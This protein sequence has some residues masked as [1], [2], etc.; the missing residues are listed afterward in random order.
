[1]ADVVEDIKAKL[2]IYTVISPHVQLK[3]TGANY[4]GCCPFHSEKTGSFIVSPQKQIFHCFG[5]NK[6]GD[7]FTFIQEFENVS[8]VEAIEILADKAGIKVKDFKK[9]QSKVSK[10][11][12]ADFFEA[13]NLAMEFYEKNLHETPAGKI[14]L[15]YLFN[16]GLKLE[17]IRE[18]HL[19]LA[20]DSYDDLYPYLIKKGVSKNTILT[21]GLAQKKELYNDQ[22]FD[23]FHSRIMFPIF[24]YIGKVCGFGG[25]ALKKDQMPKYLNSPDSPVYN[26]SKIL[27]G[28]NFAKQFVKEK[29][30]IVLVEGYFDVIMPYQ[31]G[32]KNIVASSG[33]ALTE[34]HVGII[35]RFTNN[36]VTCFDTDSA[37]EQATKR[38]YF[39]LLAKDLNV[40]TASC[41]GQKDPADFVLEE[42]SK[43]E[44]VILSAPDFVSYFIEKLLKQYD[45]ASLNGRK[46]FMNEMLPLIFPM[47]SVI[48]D[49]YIKQI[50]EKLNVSSQ[51]IYDDIQNFKFEKV[52]ARTEER[53]LEIGQ[54]DND[55]DLQDRILGILLNYPKLF[56][57]VSEQ[58]DILDFSEEYK[59]IYNQLTNQYNSTRTNFEAWDFENGDLALIKQKID[60]LCVYAEDV[61]E[62]F[63]EVILGQEILRL[64]DKFKKD[65]KTRKLKEIVDMMTKA[66]K[67]NDNEKL[68]QLLKEHQ[69][70][71]LN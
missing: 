34:F 32:I 2:D 67:D 44:E 33:T 22:I 7:I 35:K 20:G 53:V 9:F 8:F 21:L 51:I 10:D 16:R 1:M 49:F 18:F 38:S 26:K 41:F 19:G 30:S 62:S 71:L 29:D 4:K 15:D 69:T 23:K 43:F 70:L 46:S 39:L 52:D 50:A 5:C 25:R 40:K 12:K 28:L 55:I 63:S 37:G 24:D 57:Q 31:Q 66:E 56:P 60:V 54:K 48:K 45:I 61:Y 65:R 14:A 58:L 17:T 64:I 27:Y 36:V 42:G 68:V 47:Q 6:G 59:A 3:K 11:E 13:N